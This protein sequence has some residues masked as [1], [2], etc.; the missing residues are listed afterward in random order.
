MYNNKTKL[1]RRTICIWSKLEILN[2]PPRCRLVLKFTWERG[3]KIFT[4]IF[5]RRIYELM[6][7]Y[8]ITVFFGVKVQK[9]PFHRNCYLVYIYQCEYILEMSRLLH[10]LPW[11][12]VFVCVI[13]VLSVE[14]YSLFQ[15]V[16]VTNSSSILHVCAK[17]LKH[18]N[19]PTTTEH[20]SVTLMAKMSRGIFP[21]SAC[22][23]YNPS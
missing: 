15:Y 20:D 1:C 17:M 10:I 13:C 6:T 2:Q 3:N 14:T 16:L 7:K 19:H 11:M 23:N 8:P 9:L 18:L 4:Q 5:V 22:A 12:G 21:Q